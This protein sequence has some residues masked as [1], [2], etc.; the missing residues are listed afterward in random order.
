MTAMLKR[1]GSV[2]KKSMAVSAKD[3]EAAQRT[4]VQEQLPAPLEKVDRGQ[5]VVY[6]ADGYHPTHKTKTSRG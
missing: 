6:F 4:F 2:Y 1:L 5:A 3:D